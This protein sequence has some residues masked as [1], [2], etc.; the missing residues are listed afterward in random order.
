M[1]WND[2]LIDLKKINIIELYSDWKWILSG[3]INP[4]MMSKFGD[5]FFEKTDGK[6]YFLDTIEGNVVEI[7]DGIDD[8]KKFINEEENIE[9]YLLS[10][11]VFELKKLLP[12]PKENQCY[13]FKIS[14]ILGGEIVSSNVEIIDLNVSLSI[15]GQIHNRIKNLDEGTKISEI[16]FKE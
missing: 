1:N 16:K 7:C 2:L 8:F 14:P 12:L 11:L 13:A 15:L 6:I 9:N 10:Y 3:K 4:I 5:L